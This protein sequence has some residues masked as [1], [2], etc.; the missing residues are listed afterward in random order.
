[1]LLFPLDLN[2]L[3]D[4]PLLKLFLSLGGDNIDV[5]SSLTPVGN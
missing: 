5:H 3:P 1:M 4:F 2:I